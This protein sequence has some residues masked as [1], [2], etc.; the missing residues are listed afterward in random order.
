M[1]GE[2]R[3]SAAEE[4][5]NRRHFGD[6]LIRHSSCQRRQIPIRAVTRRRKKV[7]FKGWRDQRIVPGPKAT[8]ASATRRGHSA[9]DPGIPIRAMI[10]QVIRYAAQLNRIPTQA[11]TPNAAIATVKT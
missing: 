4:A 8:A 2:R 9:L 5:G 3:R 7:S 1:G 11:T 10:A 6:T